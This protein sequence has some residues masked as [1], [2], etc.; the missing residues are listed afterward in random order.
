[1]D[2]ET[3][4]ALLALGWTCGPGVDAK[5]NRYEAWYRLGESKPA[6]FFVFH[7]RLADSTVTLPVFRKK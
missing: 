2:E 6:Y 3:R 1:V 5:G 7:E 4:N